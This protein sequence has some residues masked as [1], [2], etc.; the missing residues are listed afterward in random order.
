MGE[1]KSYEIKVEEAAV[2]IGPEPQ[3]GELREVYKEPFTSP[4]TLQIPRGH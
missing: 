3:F 4:D 1:H 2:L